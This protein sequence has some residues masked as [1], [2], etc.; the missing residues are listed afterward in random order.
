EIASHG[1]FVIA[2]GYPRAEG[3]P[4]PQA[5]GEAVSRED[6]QRVADETRASQFFDALEWAK[7]A[8]QQE[9]G[10][11]H[12]KIDT[13]RVAAMGHSCGGLQTIKVSED[14]RIATS[15]VMNSGVLNDGPAAGLSGISVTKDELA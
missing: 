7:T 5:Q 4:E 14:P 15:M 1:F 2:M 11:F 9:A 13:S 12:N 3:R 6:R 8:N 10:P